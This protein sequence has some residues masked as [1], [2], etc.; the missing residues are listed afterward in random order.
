MFKL[1]V[2]LIEKILYFCDGST[3]KVATLV[4]PLWKD[5]VN[6]L[7]QK[8]EIWKWC[9]Y[10]EI[11]N[12]EL[13]NYIEKCENIIDADKWLNIYGNWSSWKNLQDN[14]QFEMM[15]CPI[16]VPRI[17]CI[18]VSG[19]F[20]VV[21]SE[22]GRVKI[23]EETWGLLHMA[24]YQAVKVTN[25]TF[26]YDG[27]TISDLGL[28][29]VGL[30]FLT[31][32]TLLTF[33]LIAIIMSNEDCVALNKRA[34]ANKF[35]TKT[36]GEKLKIINNGRPCPELLNLTTR[37][38]GKKE[39]YTCHFSVSQNPDDDE[40]EDAELDRIFLL[41]A[42][43]TGTLIL[44]E[45][46]GKLNELATIQDVKLHSV[47]QKYLCYEKRGGRITISQLCKEVNGVR[48]FCEVTFL[49]IYS[50]TAVS[51]LYVWNNVATILI[52]NQVKLL[53][54]DKLI[55]HIKSVEDKVRISFTVKNVAHQGRSYHIYST[56]IIICTFKDE[57]LHEQ[58][59]EVFILGQK[60]QYSK[61]LFNSWAALQA[62][63]TCMFLY[64]NIFIVGVD[65]GNGTPKKQKLKQEK[66][67]KEAKLLQEVELE[68]MDAVLKKV[69][70]W[71]GANKNHA[72]LKVETMQMREEFQNA[73][74]EWERMAEE[75]RVEKVELENRIKSLETK[76]IW[77]T[78]NHHNGICFIFHISLNFTKKMSSRKPLTQAELEAIVQHMIDEPDSDHENIVSSDSDLS[79]E[80]ID[81]D[82]H[83][84]SEQSASDEVPDSEIYEDSDN[85]RGKKWNK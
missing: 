27:L 74:M 4:D 50:P 65:I 22:D 19:T 16:D 80:H 53:K 42:Y 82:I 30:Q 26:M 17:T 29:C 67:L 78:K 49:R 48:M 21:G 56:N 15:L 10:E 14:V 72:D 81:V 61:K 23:F 8:T 5:I 58:F 47:H 55:P 6:F 52:N 35:S 9:C 7:S 38:K 25:I 3:L 24:R 60:D 39:E 63:I 33:I 75:W 76:L 54:F 73:K 40:T 69:D 84:L 12:A 51:C 18:A 2:E 59:L 70:K 11:P 41:L 68:E 85:Y 36:F 44:T 37:Y 45:F 31:R 83:S 34:L 28:A 1:P 66:Y 13:S 43:N 46:D 64:G 57:V 79:D 71:N 32:L 20:I 62:N 77:T